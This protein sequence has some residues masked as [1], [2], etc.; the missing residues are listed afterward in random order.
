VTSGA[1]ALLGVAAAFAVGDWLAVG[2]SH[3]KAEYVCKPA[4]TSALLAMAAV[5]SPEDSGQRTA[6][7]VALALSLIG[8]V[9]L[10]VPGDRLVVGLGAFLLAHVAFIVGFAMRDASGA[11][12]ALAV[13]LIAVPAL[14]VGSRVIRTLLTNGPREMVPPVAL[15]IL[16]IG[17]MVTSAIAVGN[18]YAIAGALLF[19]V[20][21][22]L[23]AEQ[24]FVAPRQFVPVLIMITYHVAQAGL[25]VSLV[26]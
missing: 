24:R 6:F 26:K 18:G 9:A 15:Y 19:F 3:T 4:A 14:L 16:A 11:D 12:Y 23:I 8:D 17:A 20:S 13:G 2:T 21:D 25:V 1:W 5:L 7:I 10:M 22:S